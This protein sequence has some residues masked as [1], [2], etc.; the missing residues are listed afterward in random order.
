MT[1][2]YQDIPDHLKDMAEIAFHLST[3]MNPDAAAS[4]LDNF[5]QYC[6]NTSSSSEEIQNFLHFYFNLKLEELKK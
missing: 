3:Q 4:F 5:T 2:I 6:A 1:E